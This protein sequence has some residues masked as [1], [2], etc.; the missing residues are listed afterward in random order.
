MPAEAP[1]QPSAEIMSSKSEEVQHLPHLQVKNIF[2]STTVVNVT[3]TKGTVYSF[4][5]A[6]VTST[7]NLALAGALSCL[8]AGYI[9][10][11]P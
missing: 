3:V 10:C 4:V 8:P 7:K 9:V 1:H 6:D 2:L 5:N 11:K